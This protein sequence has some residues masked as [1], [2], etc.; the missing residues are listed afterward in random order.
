MTKTIKISIVAFCVSFLAVATSVNAQINTFEEQQK[1]KS[2]REGY[3]RSPEYQQKLQHEEFKKRSEEY[4]QR[5]QQLDEQK[6]RMLPQP[7]QQQ[8]AAAAAMSQ[9]ILRRDV[10]KQQ[11]Q[12]Y[13]PLPRYSPQQREAQLKRYQA[14]REAT[15]ARIQQRIDA[16]NARKAAQ[17]PE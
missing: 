7:S 13:S 1:Y 15:R 9:E 10:F 6:R 2:L 4:R 5:Q 3:E 12:K 17:K 16:E 11:P 8:Q 14:E